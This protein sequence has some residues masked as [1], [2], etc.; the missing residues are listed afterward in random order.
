[1]QGFW[2][3]KLFNEK[4]GAKNSCT[5]IKNDKGNTVYVIKVNDEFIDPVIKTKITFECTSYCLTMTHGPE[6]KIMLVCD[7]WQENKLI[8]S[9]TQNIIVASNIKKRVAPNKRARA[10]SS[11]DE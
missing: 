3:L 11:E 8:G 5:T 10:D 7:Q 1:M 2:S 9:D 6:A 4:E